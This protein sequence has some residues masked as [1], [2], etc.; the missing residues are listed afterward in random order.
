M[1]TYRWHLD[2]LTP[3]VVCWI[4]YGD[5]H[6]F[7]EFEVISLFSGHLRWGPLTVVHQ[8][9]RITI[10]LHTV[11]P[12]TS[13]EEMDVRW[14]QFSD[15]IAPIGQICVVYGQCLPDY[16]KWFYMISHPLMTPAQPGDPPRV[17]PVQHYDT[18][19]KPDVSQQLVVVA[20]PNEPDVDVHHPRH[21]VRLLNLRIL[22]EGTK[23]YIVTEECLSIVRSYIGQPTRG[24]K[25]RHRRH[26]DDH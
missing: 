24:H 17:L 8:P 13:V 9:K 14:M 7:R 18:F 26:M 10:L 5:H 4:P 25:S 1:S 2:R 19:V 16:M 6:S 22:I 21:V 11:A 23:V 12:S 15:Y 3:N 20:A